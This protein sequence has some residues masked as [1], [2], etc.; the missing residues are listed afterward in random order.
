MEQDS[1]KSSSEEIK[2]RIR[3]SKEKFIPHVSIYED[4]HSDLETGRGFT[5]EEYDTCIKVHSIRRSFS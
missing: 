2:Q 3:F 4:V 5:G 1:R